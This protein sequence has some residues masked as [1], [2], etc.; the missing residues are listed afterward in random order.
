M[1]NNVLKNLKPYEVFKYFEEITQIPRGSGNEKGISDYLVAFAKEHNLEVI[2]D[3][4]LNVIIKKPGTAGYEG[5]PTIVLQGHMDMVNE[6][7][8]GTEHDFDKD[9]LKLRVEG[10]MLYATGT[11]L[12]ADNGIAMAYAMALLASKDIAHPPVEAL[13]TTDE[14]A[15]MS[16]AMALNPEHINGRIL[17]NIDS[18]EEGKLLVSCAGGVRVSVTLPIKWEDIKE[19]KTPIVIRLR[20]LKGGHSGMEIHK[21]RGN[22]NKIMG[23]ILYDLQDRVSYNLCSLNGGAKNNAIP[24]EADAVLLVN[25][26]DVEGLKA[27]A[28]S[29]NE[30]LKNELKASDPDVNVQ[31]EVLPDRYNKMFSKETTKKAVQLLYLIPSGIQT[32][33]MEIAGLVQSSTNLGVVT[34]SKDMITY[35]SATRSS[36]KT[37]KEDLV[38]QFKLLAEVVGVECETRADYPDWQYDA[39]SKIRRVFERVYKEMTGNDPEIVAIHAGVECG[40][41]KEKFGEMDMISFGPNLYDVHTPD[42]HISISSTERMWNYLIAVLKEIK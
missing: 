13:M 6:K 38:N 5:A 1:S 8:Q 7:N 2:Q 22:S 16:G 32:M 14:E 4:A 10:D 17:I 18:E 37:L 21:G 28:S 34:T 23:R 29:W 11:T 33:S 27:V 41:F 26:E 9:P 42:E 12:G 20:G 36:V 3:E 31:V 39:D 24:R 35:D 19:D 15:G 40:L 30:V 25:K